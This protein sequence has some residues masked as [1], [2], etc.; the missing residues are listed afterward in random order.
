MDK[1]LKLLFLFLLCAGRLFAQTPAS[2]TGP[3]PLTPY[4][5][6]VNKVWWYDQRTLTWYPMAGTGG[7]GDTVSFQKFQFK[8]TG[9]ATSAHIALD[10]KDTTGVDSLLGLKNNRLYRVKSSGTN[11]GNSDLTQS[12][13]HDKGYLRWGL[14]HYR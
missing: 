13:T 9:T 1:S 5:D 12:L 2:P 3:I 11:L 8:N 4:L 10:A 14:S 6:N 7:G